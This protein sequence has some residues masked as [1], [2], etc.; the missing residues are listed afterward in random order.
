M[1]TRRQSF[2][3]LLIIGGILGLAA[4]SVTGILALR[5]GHWLEGFLLLAFVV[6]MIAFDGRTVVHVTLKA[7]IVLFFLTVITAHLAI[8]PNGTGE[9]MDLLLWAGALVI[10][11]ALPVAY[12]SRNSS[13]RTYRRWG[14]WLTGTGVL[15]FFG[16]IYGEML[17]LLEFNLLLGF[18]WFPLLYTGLVVWTAG[19]LVAVFFAPVEPDQ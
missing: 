8:S 11:V 13:A 9:L 3:D 18:G 4:V 17:D 1:T 6:A 15:G 10:V 16:V 19:V 7:A 2:D 5:Y 12:L 14:V